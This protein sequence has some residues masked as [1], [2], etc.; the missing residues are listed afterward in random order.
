MIGEKNQIRDDL[1]TYLDHLFTFQKNLPKAALMGLIPFEFKFFDN[2]E[3]FFAVVG[4]TDYFN[5][6][7]GFCFGFEIVEHADNDYEVKLYVD[8]QT[9]MGGA[10]GVAIPSQLQPSWNP[11][12]NTVRQKNYE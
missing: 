1:E 8:D 3:D 7:N 2:K 11:T 9:L 10:K 6:D 12:Q 4:G 5:P